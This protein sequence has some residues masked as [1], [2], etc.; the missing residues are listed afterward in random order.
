[1]P[2][3]TKK[4]RQAWWRSLTEEEQL[5]KIAYWQKTKRERQIS[6]DGYFEHRTKLPFIATIK[7]LDGDEFWIVVNQ[8]SEGVF[9]ERLF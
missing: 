2:W 4:E 3:K 6:R 1:M 7:P 9:S 5:D 8:D